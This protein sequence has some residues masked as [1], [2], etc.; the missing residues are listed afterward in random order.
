MIFQKPSN[1]FKGSVSI[2]G[3]LCPTDKGLRFKR[4]NLNT[5]NR[6]WTINVSE[7]TRVNIFKTPG[8]VNN[9]IEIV[10]DKQ[11][12]EKFVVDK[13]KQWLQSIGHIKTST[14]E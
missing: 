10:T 14:N 12:V 7:I 1:H 2:G 6:E 11:V 3:H 8:L 4:Y 13:Q 5:Q 9:G